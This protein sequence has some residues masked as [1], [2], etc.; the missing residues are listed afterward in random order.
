MSE[1]VECKDQPDAISIDPETISD[2]E[3]VIEDADNLTHSESQDETVSA[4]TENSEIQ[5]KGG[6]DVDEKL[7]TKDET[8]SDYEDASDEVNENDDAAGENLT[9]DN[10]AGEDEATQSDEQRQEPGSHLNED[11]AVHDS[12]EV[13]SVTPNTNTDSL[14][15][16]NTAKIIDAEKEPDPQNTPSKRKPS[17]IKSE[18][19][20]K[21]IVESENSLFTEDNAILPRS[22][23]LADRKGAFT[24]MKKEGKADLLASFI[25]YEDQIPPTKF[26]RPRTSFNDG[27]QRMIS[28]NKSRQSWPMTEPKR[29]RPSTSPLPNSTRQLG[30]EKRRSL[31][32]ALE[33]SAK[34]SYDPS[35][36]DIPSSLIKRRNAFSPKTPESQSRRRSQREVGLNKHH[37]SVQEHKKETQ[38][39]RRNN[40]ER[41][42][43]N[44]LSTAVKL[45]SSCCIV[46][47]CLT[48]IGSKRSILYYLAENPT[49]WVIRFFVIL[50]HAVFILVEMNVFIPGILPRGTLNNFV[51]RAFVQSFIGLVDISMNS[52]RSLVDYDGSENDLERWV[53]LAFLV[54]RVSPRGLLAC[55]LL[56]FILAVCG[57]DGQSIIA[58]RRF[59]EAIEFDA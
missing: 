16:E 12:T 17:L 21:L 34:K 35:D 25:E 58:S 46:A 1:Q 44:I 51:H 7:C 59:I 54:L 38:P 40:L 15:I 18:G 50:F 57:K 24:P 19:R 23:T 47:R 6:N 49:I 10:N 48:F 45:F 31:P 29:S 4:V 33:F 53:D 11:V 36:Y 39:N 55:S 22:I 52:N 2:E 3:A 5:S 13:D 27:N 56:Y 43:L 8:L 14:P 41:A 26:P 30:N 28:A 9:N 32:A 37:L 20:R 42:A